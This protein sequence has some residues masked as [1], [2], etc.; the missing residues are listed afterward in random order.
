MQVHLTMSAHANHLVARVSGFRMV[1]KVDETLAAV[2][3]EMRRLQL[4]RVLFDLRP[5]IGVITEYDRGRTIDLLF[6]RLGW[7]RCAL[8]IDPGLYT[9]VQHARMQAL[10]LV[11]GV[12]FDEAQAEAWLTSDAPPPGRPDPGA[13]LSSS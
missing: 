11:A 10:G 7:A 4:G 9:G 3:A 2:E 12:F 5:L 8:L 13:T 1:D 6:R